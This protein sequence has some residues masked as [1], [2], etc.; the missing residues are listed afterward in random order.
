MKF[1][2]SLVNFL[3]LTQ[4]IHSQTYTDS[5]N[6]LKNE[7]DELD[8][9]IITSKKKDIKKSESPIPTTIVSSELF[10]KSGATN[11]FDGMGMINGIQSQVNCNV[12]NTGDIHI[13]G[14]DGPYTLIL[15][16]GTPIVSGLSTVYGLNG[17]PTSMIDRV[18]IIKGPASAQYGAEAMGGV[19]NIITK[20]PKKAP[21][22]STDLSGSSWGEINTDLTLKIKAGKK[23]SSLLGLNYFYYDNPI[24]KN[25]DG[26]T[27]L[28]LQNRISVFNKWSFRRN[29]NRWADFALRWINE[30]R[31]GGQM[32]WNKKYRGGDEVYG[33][34][35]YT[36]RLEVL[37]TYQLP[38][39][40]KVYTQFSYNWHNQNSWYGNKPFMATQQILFAQTYWN[41]NIHSHNLMLGA[42]FRYTYYDDN[43]P[44]TA[45]SDGLK[46]KP[47]HRYLPGF[48]VED[49][50]NF[51]DKNNLLIGYRYDNDNIHGSINSPRIAYKY[52]L[53]SKNTFR[54][55][56]GNGFRVVNIFTEDHAALTGARDVIIKNTLKPEKS[57]NSNINYTTNLTTNH[58]NLNLDITGFYSYFT[59]KIVADLDT[60]PKKIIYNNLD[61]HAISNGISLDTDWTFTFPLKITTGITYMNVYTREKNENGDFEQK[62]QLYSP[63]WSGNLILNY[64]FKNKLS[65]D[66]TGNWK[67][68]MRLPIQPN[69]YRKEYSPWQ[70]IANIQITKGFTNG[71]EIYGGIKNLLNIKPKNPLMRP[72]DPFDKTADDPINNPFGYTFDTAY[73][74]ASMQ[75]IRGFLGVRYTVF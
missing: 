60:D 51:N 38:I 58:F 15:I 52:K 9:V 10:K 22:L 23:V 67:G 62:N 40:E 42:T 24:D 37:G 25:H 33:E 36:K 53:D 17:I 19:I 47:S 11:F 35:I 21:L 20:N 7:V 63:K 74:Y 50:W 71:F 66:L 29:E 2:L 8:K 39:K 61:G 30:D 49:N 31:W 16:D 65:I 3:F 32:N 5:L 4:L 68:P 1:Y 6:Y 46:N 57:Y 64:S 28:T 55:S 43:T 56:L 72:F 12:C 34:S 27:D 75:G 45:S 48:F 54:M 70:W 44:A 73:N 41:K 18:E 69:D 59:N 13:N 14:M 26:F